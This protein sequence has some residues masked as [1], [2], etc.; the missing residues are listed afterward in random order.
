M[1]TKMIINSGIQEVVYNIDYPLNA[2]ASQLLTEAGIAVRKLS[3]NP[4]A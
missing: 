3:L 2:V 4:T 1:C